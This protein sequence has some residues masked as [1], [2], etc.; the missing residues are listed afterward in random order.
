MSYYRT[1]IK[2]ILVQDHYFCATTNRFFL[3]NLQLLF[4]SSHMRLCWLCLGK[5]E[6]MIS[7]YLHSYILMGGSI[8]VESFLCLPIHFVGP[9][10]TLELR[11]S[12]FLLKIIICRLNM[13]C[14]PWCFLCNKV[15][16]LNLQLTFIVHPTSSFIDKSFYYYCCCYDKTWFISVD[17]QVHT[18]IHFSDG[19]V[20]RC[21]ISKEMLDENQKRTRLGKVYT[22][23]PLNQMDIYT[24]AT[25]RYFICYWCFDRSTYTENSGP[26]HW[27]GHCLVA[28]GPND[29]MD[30][31][32]F[33]FR[34]WAFSQ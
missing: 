19:F 34:L 1:K 18:E 21:C 8:W 22:S 11:W 26:W 2:T 16:L 5:A 27:L 24:M 13:L 17:Y 31:T 30:L 6:V 12:S 33:S 20:L 32:P 23:F 29:P 25:L 10:H 14:A 7:D 15:F 3:L 9:C 4:T 28:P